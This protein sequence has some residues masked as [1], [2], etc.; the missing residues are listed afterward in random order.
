MSR[1]TYILGVLCFIAIAV[2]AVMLICSVNIRRL[3]VRFWSVFL[4]ASLVSSFAFYGLHKSVSGK[5]TAPTIDFSGISPEIKEPE[6]AETQAP[7][8]LTAETPG[9]DGQTPENDSSSQQPQYA[10]EEGTDDAEYETD[11]AQ[12]P[13]TSLRPDTDTQPE[14]EP[15]EEHSADFEAETEQDTES[16]S[17]TSDQYLTEDITQPVYSSAED[18]PTQSDPD[19]VYEGPF[20]A[21]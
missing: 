7:D 8:T 17:D 2:S 13:R 1:L 16:R 3:N 19:I 20:R 11:A 9:Q 10:A 5:K 21:E 4:C 14:T 18:Y 15:E 6:E 12:K